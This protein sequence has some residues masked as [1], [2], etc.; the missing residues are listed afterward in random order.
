MVGKPDSVLIR[1]VS[2]IQ[3]CI[4][5]SIS[6]HPDLPGMCFEVAGTLLGSLI[7]GIAIALSGHNS[8]TACIQGGT[9]T[10]DDALEGA[11]R[12]GALTVAVVAILA[13]L[14]PFFGVKEQ[15]GGLWDGP[16]WE[17]H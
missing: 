15:R 5:L 13:G 2:L 4:P 1:E 12:Y 9:R 10:Y 14:V 17:V 8:N 3:P 11:Y 6:A 16:L 7:Q